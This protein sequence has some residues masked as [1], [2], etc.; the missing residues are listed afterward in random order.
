MIASQL[1]DTLYSRLSNRTFPVGSRKIFR[2]ELQSASE[3]IA[4][5]D[6]GLVI[7]PYDD[8]LYLQTLIEELSK[9]KLIVCQFEILSEAS[10]NHQLF[11]GKRVAILYH[12]V[13]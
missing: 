4:K 7:F 3:Y 13:W 11:N 2:N 10:S 5:N 6:R 1:S 9:F 12:T 8:V